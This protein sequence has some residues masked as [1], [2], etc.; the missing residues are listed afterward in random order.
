MNFKNLK[1]WDI[2]KTCVKSLVLSK[3]QV[4]GVFLKSTR[5]DYY[6][7]HLNLI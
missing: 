6:Q 5:P 7:L 1:K 4:F 3:F 2:Y